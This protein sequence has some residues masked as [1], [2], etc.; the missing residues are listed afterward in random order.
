MRPFPSLPLNPH[1]SPPPLSLFPSHQ[2]TLSLV[3]VCAPPAHL[4]TS[5]RHFLLFVTE[6]ALIE[7]RELAPLHELNEAILEDN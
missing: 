6:F 2:L 5:Y 4:N 3:W 7:P 1:P